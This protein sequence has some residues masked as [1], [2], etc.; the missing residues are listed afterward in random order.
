M[1]TAGPGCGRHGCS[2]AALAS[3]CCGCCWWRASRSAN[4]VG[5]HI[6]GSIDGWSSGCASTRATSSSG[7]CCSYAATA[8]GWWWMRRRLR[9]REPLAETHQRLLRAEIAA[10]ATLVLLEG[11]LLRN[12]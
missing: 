2:A 10:V 3:C 12:G 8:Y 5:L 9:E 11:Q 1:T 7:G 6:V 4:V